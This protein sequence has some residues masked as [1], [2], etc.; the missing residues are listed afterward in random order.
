MLW[1]NS[2]LYQN[3]DCYPLIKG[4]VIFVILLLNPI[5]CNINFKI[6]KNSTFLGNCSVHVSL[7]CGTRDCKSLCKELLDGDNNNAK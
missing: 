5:T 2:I 6:Y 3:D 1:Y 7:I 4:V